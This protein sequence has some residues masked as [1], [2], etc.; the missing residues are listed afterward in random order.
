MGDMIWG[1]LAAGGGITAGMALARVLDDQA[2]QTLIAWLCLSILVFVAATI[3]R[4]VEY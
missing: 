1:A 4:A 3:I 2:I